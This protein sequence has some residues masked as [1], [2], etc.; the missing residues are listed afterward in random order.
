MCCYL[1]IFLCSASFY[2]HRAPDRVQRQCKRTS[3]ALYVRRAASLK[4]SAT[5]TG[6]G[7]VPPTSSAK[8][9]PPPSTS[10]FLTRGSHEDMCAEMALRYLGAGKQKF[11]SHAV[12]SV[13]HPERPG[14]P[15]GRGQY[16]L[17]CAPTT[18]GDGPMPYLPVSSTAAAP[19]ALCFPGALVGHQGLGL[20]YACP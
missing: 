14:L 5:M 4:Q 12:S 3:S 19:P 7:G 8:S 16:P 6:M 18:L 9:L 15:A 10:L 1:E 2:M 11:L 13:L 17:Q 20:Y